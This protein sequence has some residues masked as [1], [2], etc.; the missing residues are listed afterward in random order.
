MLRFREKKTNLSSFV[1]ASVDCEMTFN[2]TKISENRTE[3][4]KLP[5]SACHESRHLLDCNAI[6][7][8]TIQM[9][10]FVV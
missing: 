9:W 3:N 10:E 7:C 6:S 5:C 4:E 2:K 1:T 8:H